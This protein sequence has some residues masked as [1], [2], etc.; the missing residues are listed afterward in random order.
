MDRFRDV[1]R[2]CNL[3]HDLDVLPN[4]EHT[5]L[6]EKGINLSGELHKLTFFSA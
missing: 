5:E 2:A 1:I 3:D 4:G 6:G